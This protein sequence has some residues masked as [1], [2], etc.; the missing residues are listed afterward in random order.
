MPKI[1]K[2]CYKL[3][4]CKSYKNHLQVNVMQIIDQQKRKNIKN[5]FD[6]LWSQRKG[7]N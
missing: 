6:G 7:Y 3:I 4:L 2:S 5:N 1:S